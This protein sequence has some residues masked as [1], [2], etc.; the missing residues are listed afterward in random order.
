VLRFQVDVHFYGAGAL[1]DR[2]CFQGESYLHIESA[3]GDGVPDAALSRLAALTPLMETPA[4][5][6]GVVA[7]PLE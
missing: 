3:D 5:A 6:D 7:R 2:R 1:H 4:S